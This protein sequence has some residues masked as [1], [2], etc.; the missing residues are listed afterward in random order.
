ME[1]EQSEPAFMLKLIK[2]FGRMYLVSVV[3]RNDESG[4][5]KKEIHHQ[6]GG[7]FFDQ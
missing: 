2:A 1:W 7:A 4:Q 3:E 6:P 5:Y